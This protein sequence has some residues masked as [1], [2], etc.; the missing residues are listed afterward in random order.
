MNISVSLNNYD[1]DEVIIVIIT[2]IATVIVI[3]INIIFQ[4]QKPNLVMSLKLR[5]SR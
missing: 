2:I 1:V 5:N 3:I 4:W